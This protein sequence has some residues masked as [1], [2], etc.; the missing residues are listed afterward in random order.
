MRSDRDED[1][2]RLRAQL[3]LSGLVEVAL[4]GVG[5]IR[6]LLG[7]A[8]E[9]HR[10]DHDRNAG[11]ERERRIRVEPGVDDGTEPAAADQAGDHDHREREEDRLVDPEQQ[12]PP[13]ERELHLRE[14]LPA[15]RAHRRR[16]L[17]G[18]RRDA[19]DP[20]RGDPDGGRNR[21]DDRRDDGGGVADREEEHDRHQVREGR[22][23]LHRVEH[24]VDRALEAIRSPGDDSDRN[25]D[26]R[27]RARRT[28]SSA[29][30]SPCSPARGRAMRTRQRRRT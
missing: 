8:V 14:H 5:A 9:R 15:R 24:G 19:A 23:D 11:E 6:D 4:G 1:S 16:R 29:R 3:L 17:D 26:Q 12:H 2:E 18:V 13:R 28:R 10:H 27:A 30:A 7:H 22:N 20:E 25:A 21:V